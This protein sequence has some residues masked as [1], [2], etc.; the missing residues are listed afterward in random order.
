MGRTRRCEKVKRK[1]N[2]EKSEKLSCIIL[3]PRKL[4]G[5]ILLWFR[6]KKKKNLDYW[7]TRNLDY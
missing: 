5:A 7:G 2:K 4:L 3:K 1:E 6:K